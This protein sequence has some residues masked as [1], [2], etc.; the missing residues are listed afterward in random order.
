VPRA[1]TKINGLTQKLD[2]F[3]TASLPLERDGTPLN[4]RISRIYILT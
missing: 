2:F 4:S 1:S 3:M